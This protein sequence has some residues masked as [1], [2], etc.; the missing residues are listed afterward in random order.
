MTRS[1]E[2]AAYLDTITAFPKQFKPRIH[3]A[4]QKYRRTRIFVAFQTDS[5]AARMLIRRFVKGSD[6]KAID[7]ISG[8][9]P[10][11][12]EQALLMLNFYKA[13]EKME[14]TLSQEWIERI[15]FAEKEP[16][17]DIG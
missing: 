4:F 8:T 2:F 11:T 14:R 7:A 10:T 12:E 13:G 3:V 16:E 15:R 6:G 17:Y 9:E 1:Q 5:R